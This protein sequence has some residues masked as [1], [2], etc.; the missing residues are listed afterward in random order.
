MCYIKARSDENPYFPKE[1]YERRRA[2]MDE[3]RFRMMFGGEFERMEGLVYDCF[4]DE[5]N[6]CEYPDFD[7]G[8][9]YYAGIDW[10]YTEPFAMAIHAI[11]PDGRRYQVSETKK[12]R[13]TLTEIVDICR[14]KRQV[15]GVEHFFC[16]PSQPGYIEE[17]NRAGIPA[18]GANNDIKRGIAKVYEELKTRRFKIVR[19]TSPHTID[20]IETYHYPE[21]ADLLPDRSIKEVNPVGQND[22]ML[23]CIR[24]LTVST[25]DIMSVRK[26]V[27]GGQHGEAANNYERI[28]RLLRNPNASGGR[29][30]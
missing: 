8:V 13:L 9:R 16:D 19:N 17:L 1:E 21:P 26:P 7:S 6:L 24:Y 25:L 28:Q 30:W 11:Y 3:R 12:A 23:D 22:H 18:S 14:Q 27:Q 20:E 15:F 4:S 29:S 5:E 10:G 2:T